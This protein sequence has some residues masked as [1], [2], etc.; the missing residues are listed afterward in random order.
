MLNGGAHN[1]R[2]LFDAAWVDTSFAR[3]QPYQP[4]WGLLWWRL[5]AWTRYAVD[6]ARLDTLRARGVDEAFVRRLEPMRDWTFE[7]RASYAAALEGLLGPEWQD[8]L[9]ERLGPT[10]LPLA[11]REHSPD[12]VAY[13]ADGYRGNFLVVVPEAR[14]VAARV[15]GPSEDFDPARHTFHDFPEWVAALAACRP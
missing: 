4:L 1:G 3:S 14:L 6:G 10:G 5:P 9:N 15:R 7:D 12:A 8:L 13:Y 2:R 11:R